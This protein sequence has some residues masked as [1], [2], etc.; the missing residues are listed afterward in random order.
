[1]RAIV[2]RTGPVLEQTLYLVSEL[3]LNSKGKTLDSE[4]ASAGWQGLSFS[5]NPCLLLCFG[6]FFLGLFFCFLF[7]CLKVTLGRG[8]AS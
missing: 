7:L 3:S 6:V 8:H 4:S 2:V 1:M 5:Q